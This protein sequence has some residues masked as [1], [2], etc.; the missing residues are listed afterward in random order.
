MTMT[1]DGTP[2]N[3]CT[4]AQSRAL[5]VRASRVEGIDGTFT[6]RCDANGTEK[7]RRLAARSTRDW[8]ASTTPNF[9]QLN[10]PQAAVPFVS[11]TIY[12]WLS[13]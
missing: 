9:A 3:F 4:R 11:G 12:E 2:R 13:R 8:R 10:A 1:N 5:R 6:L 7:W